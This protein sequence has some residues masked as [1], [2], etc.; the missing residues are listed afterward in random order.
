[1]WSKL[2]KQI[3]IKKQYIEIA[4]DYTFET[5]ET[6]DTFE[7]NRVKDDNYRDKNDR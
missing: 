3:N 6:F 2:C 4:R 7:S 5:F 1:M